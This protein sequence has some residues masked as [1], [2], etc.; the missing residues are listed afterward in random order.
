MVVLQKKFWDH[1]KVDKGV[2]D[3]RSKMC[4]CFLDIR[5]NKVVQERV[6]STIVKTLSSIRFEDEKHVNLMRMGM[7]GIECFW[8][9]S[10]EV[11]MVLIVGRKKQCGPVIGVL[12][13]EK[14][15]TLDD[16][17]NT[18]SSL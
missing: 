6:H 4:G 12:R 13:S 16:L 15:R 8:H 14:L 1:F 3:S 9:L 10:Q 5:M 7:N 2:R 11:R 17:K 18:S